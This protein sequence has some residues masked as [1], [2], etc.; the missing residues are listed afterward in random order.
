VT[1][2][3]SPSVGQGVV[4]LFCKVT[5]LAEAGAITAAVEKAQAE[6]DQVVTVAVLGHK[7]DIAFMALGLDL[8]RLRDLQA[9]LQEA[10]LDVVDSYVSLTEL[11]EYAQGVPE[12]MRQARLRPQLPPEGKAAFC[13][14]PMSKRREAE[15][16]WFTLD[17]D[18]RKEMMYEHGASG[19]KFAGRVLQ[20]VTGSA[21]VDDFEWGVTLFAERPDDLKEVVYTMRFDR[22]SA[23]YAEFGTFYSGMVGT[24]DEVLDAAGVPAA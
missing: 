12:Q 14:Y 3:V 21:G 8:W 23:L 9:A 1:E 19:R 10:G 6:G 2:S 22:A 17:Y 18:D 7:A 13:F 15:H 5:P 16:N 4:H 20:V 24:L 11:S